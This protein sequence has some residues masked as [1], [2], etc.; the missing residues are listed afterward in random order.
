[1]TRAAQPEDEVR[2][3]PGDDE[4]PPIGRVA[5]DFGV[6]LRI[7]VALI[8][9]LWGLK[10][11]QPTF[12]VSGA[13]ES[14]FVYTVGGV[15]ALALACARPTGRWAARLDLILLVGTIVAIGLWTRA[16]VFGSPAYGTDEVAFDQGAAQLLLHEINPYG[17]D[18]SWTFDAFRVLPSGTTNTLGGDFVHTLSYPAGAFLA[19]VPLLAAGVYGQA[20]IYMDALFWIIGLCTLWWALPNRYRPV[21]PILGSLGIYV[22]YATGGVTDPLMM[23]FMV[24]ALWRWDRFG[25]TTER[26]SARWI[27][28]IA[29]GIACTFKQSAWFIV[30]MLVTAITIESMSAGRGWRP[31]LRY[32]ALAAIAFI[33]P[34]LPFILLDP[35]AWVGGVFLPFLEPLVPFGQG[36]IA[37]ST[38]FFQGGGAL[39]AYT[40]AGAAVMVAV[41]AAFVGWYGRLKP[42]L[43]VL[44]LVALLLPTRSLNSYFVYAIPG[45]LVAITTIRPAPPHPWPHGRVLRGAG[46]FAALAASAVGVLA[47]G[48]AILTP[49]P[50]V[51]EPIGQHTT[52]QLQTVDSLTVV[53][54][55]HSDQPLKPHFSVALGA[56]MSNF[57][58]VNQGPEVVPPHGSA[59][60]VL[61]A[62]N[63]ASMPNVAQESVLFALTEKPSTISTA[64]LFAATTD[65]TEITPQA[66]NW[67][68]TDPP[69]VTFDVAVVDRLNNPVRKAGLEVSLGQVLYTSEGLFPGLASINGKPEGQ[70]PVTALTNADGV[71]H[72]VARAVQQQQHEVFFQ[73]WLQ[74][75]F[76]HGYSGLVSVHFIVGAP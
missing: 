8:W 14:G 18:L 65:R 33:I 49:A 69:E 3:H 24:L 26:S 21:V 34:N 5:F 36:F 19:Y 42:L 6:V 56:Y 67:I 47:L 16:A 51:L 13:P 63:A 75:P 35:R 25:D 40:A 39:P 50:F 70:S 9:I 28:P 66:V 44:P 32:V 45:L 72:F 31:V 17:V 57:W 41:I 62:P 12:T 74:Q 48:V 58:V 73:A 53:A 52:G 2:A 20:A 76:P 43:P 15:I 27:G 38:T 37:F 60:Y 22:D 61:V 29:L 7:M 30:P 10:L 71:A 46:R 11:Y 1:M 23:P 68:V 54:E 64:R 55:N 4:S 59:T